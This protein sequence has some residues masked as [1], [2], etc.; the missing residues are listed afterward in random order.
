MREGNMS[1]ITDDNPFI[2]A[3]TDADKAAT[4]IQTVFRG[5]K[6]RK[7]LKLVHDA[8]TKIQVLTRGY[9]ERKH[10]VDAMLEGGEKDIKDKL[11]NKF[12]SLYKIYCARKK[13]EEQNEAAT[14]IQS[15][16]RENQS[17]EELAEQNESALTIQSV[18]RGYRARKAFNTEMLNN[19]V[20]VIK[21]DNRHIYDFLQDIQTRINHSFLQR[22]IDQDVYNTTLD[23][24]TD[25]INQFKDFHEKL[26]N[27][28]ENT[29]EV[30]RKDFTKQNQIALES[31][32]NN[33]YSICKDIGFKD[34]NQ[35]LDVI[36]GAGWEE[37]MPEESMKSLEFFN[38]VFIPT[39]F[40]FVEVD[41]ES[42]EIHYLK[43]ENGIIKTDFTDNI[44]NEQPFPTEM[45]FFDSKTLYNKLNGGE[46]CIPVDRGNDKK[47]LLV[48]K[49]HYGNDPLNLR[50]TAGWLSRK[51]K[52][53]EKKLEE[54]H[55]PKIFTKK[56]FEQ[57]SVRD[58]VLKTPSAIESD[59]LKAH[60]ELE[61]LKVMMLPSLVR[62]FVQTPIE[63]QI[64]ILSLLTM[65]NENSNGYF[66]YNLA[67]K[68]TP[69]LKDAIR[70]CLHYSI[71]KIYDIKD[72]E[73]E[74]LKRK[75]AQAGN[76]DVPYE[77]RVLATA[78]EEHA[79]IKA[80]EKAKAAKSKGSESDKAEAWLNGILKLPFGKYV[81]ESVTGESDRKDIK[82]HMEK[83]RGILDESVH[84]HEDAKQTLLRV[85][86]QWISSGSS[87]GEVLAL[88]GPPGNGKTTFAKEGVAKALGRPFGFLPLGG[89][90]DSAYL[91]GHEYTYVGATW[92][93]IADILMEAGCMNPV[94]Y[95]DEL[96]KV[97][98]TEKGR[99]IIG[100]L[101][102]LTDSSQNEKFHD[103]YFSGINLDLSKALI[104]FSYND[105][106]MIDPILKDRMITIRTKAHATKDKLV[107]AQD[108][109]LPG[110]LKTIGFNREDISIDNEDVKF[111]VEN[112]TYEAGVRRLKEYLFQIVR[113]L[114]L[115]RLLDPDFQLPH[116]IDRDT[117]I[118]CLDEPK[119]R[120][121]KIPEKPLLGTVNG[122]FATSAGLG[123]LTIIQTFKTL[124]KNMFELKLTGSQG[125]VMQES[126][127]TALTVAQNLLPE[128][129]KKEIQ[130][131]GSF[132]LHIHVPEAAQPKDGPSAG[133]AI[134]VSIISRIL[135]IPIK[136]DVAMTGEIDLRGSIT[137]I[138]GLN[139]KLKG[140]KDAGATQVFC[141]KEN[142][143]DLEKIK[144]ESPELFDGN[145]S[146]TLVENIH[147]LLKLTLTED[148]E[149][150]AID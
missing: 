109:L 45:R 12:Q 133:G 11:L 107:I 54:T 89:I 99:E 43:S 93:R 65:D 105:E 138:G 147:Q 91:L 90:T 122:L 127:K 21:A 20:E 37:V 119:I 137:A 39:G 112:Y 124:S 5:Y 80:F 1:I 8:A 150:P 123:G 69:E 6:V 120:F 131:N 134:T 13:S 46:L 36:L 140:A 66:L 104:V 50:S 113:E 31:I 2:P 110:I 92:G 95:I 98:Q 32:H 96:D 116:K 68:E 42:D 49:G 100:V 132:G 77:D 17:R 71:Q 148:R 139:Y 84:G 30:N 129:A 59:M 63:K 81:Q 26:E 145:F 29:P 94:I 16:Y 72:A 27:Y 10:L 115:D 74:A 51:R 19:F 103:K 23:K 67:G 3:S 126:M 55:L 88:Q 143:K 64:R 121:T 15:V 101:T 24:M 142:E 38:Q 18:Y 70:R 83:V 82:A 128:S 106:S 146:V 130:E 56:F 52:I 48:V 114:N 144:K 57:Y 125:D 28:L 40:T 136:N 14:K 73:L 85:V 75:L 35:G 60:K 86:G 4:K 78:M 58:L 118:K 111:I 25:I 61:K 62:T 87:S 117:I 79:K 41:T 7:H 34:L 44:L 108:Y 76:D 135:G 102:H 141:P 22:V 97:S 9:L 149:F 47:E 53:I 33:I